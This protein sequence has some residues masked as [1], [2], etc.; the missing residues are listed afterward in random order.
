LSEIA[1]YGECVSPASERLFT[2]QDERCALWMLKSL[3]EQLGAG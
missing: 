3:P 1:L 2:R